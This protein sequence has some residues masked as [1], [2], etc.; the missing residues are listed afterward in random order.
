MNCWNNRKIVLDSEK[1]R[2]ENMITMLWS[3]EESLKQLKTIRF[4]FFF[5]TFSCDS[6]LKVWLLELRGRSCFPPCTQC[7]KARPLASCFCVEAVQGEYYWGNIHTDYLHHPVNNKALRR[8]GFSQLKQS[9]SQVLVCLFFLFWFLHL[10]ANS[11]H[12]IFVCAGFISNLKENG[13][14]SWNSHLVRGLCERCLTLSDMLNIQS[15][16]QNNTY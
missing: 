6:E 7:F 1:R 13:T 4:R 2:E 5:Y 12:V 11:C 8:F 9:T 16:K 14:K 10:G 15:V 3:C